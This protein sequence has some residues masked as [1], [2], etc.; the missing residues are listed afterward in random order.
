MGRQDLR[1]RTPLRVV[2]RCP[3]PCKFFEK[4]LTKNFYLSLPSLSAGFWASVSQ[5][6]PPP[7]SGVRDLSAQALGGL[8]NGNEE[9][10]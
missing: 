1:S 2:G 4:N 5:K 9:V 3:T 6:T 7:Q 10:G 8:R